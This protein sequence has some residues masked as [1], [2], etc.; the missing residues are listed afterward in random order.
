MRE[1]TIET[2]VTKMLV[3]A[4]CLAMKAGK[5]GWPDHL[6]ICPDGTILWIEFKTPTGRVSPSQSRKLRQLRSRRHKAYVIR[7][8]DG[9]DVKSALDFVKEHS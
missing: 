6:Y 7:T 2:R 3:D 9:F 4:G 5:N 1:S 8:V